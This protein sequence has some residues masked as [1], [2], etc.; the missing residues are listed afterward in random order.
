MTYEGENKY[1]DIIGLPRHV[2][3]RHP[4]MPLIDRAAQFSPFAALTGHDAAIRET[5]RLAE[6]RMEA[7]GR[8]K[9]EDGLE[10]E[11]RLAE[12]CPETEGR[13]EWE[14]DLEAEGSQEWEDGLETEG[15]R[16]AW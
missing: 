1:D 14:E 11:G 6:T 7:E 8:L 3:P 13:Q 9:G 16:E 2:S 15:G 10:G 12:D 5:A 4:Q